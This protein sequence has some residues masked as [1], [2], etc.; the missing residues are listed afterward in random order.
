MPGVGRPQSFAPLRVMVIFRWPSFPPSMYRPVLPVRCPAPVRTTSTKG[1]ADRA[2]LRGAEDG[3]RHVLRGHRSTT[4][5]RPRTI[6]VRG[7]AFRRP[8]RSP[9]GSRDRLPTSPTSAVRTLTSALCLLTS[10]LCLLHSDFRTLT[11]AYR[12]FSSPSPS[13]P[14]RGEKYLAKS[15]GR[16]PVRVFR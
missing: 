3:E 14:M 6:R 7:S 8:A 1:G 11:S 10:V 13:I 12:L 5:Y 15:S 2:P 16:L 9:P 4:C